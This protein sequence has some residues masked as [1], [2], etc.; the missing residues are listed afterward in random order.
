MTI[1][2]VRIQEGVSM[3]GNGRRRRRAGLL[4]CPQS[5]FLAVG[6][7]GGRLLDVSTVRIQGVAG[8]TPAPVV[9]RILAEASRHRA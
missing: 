3:G 4:K 6:L 7:L 5:T 8:S 1:D 9:A 2:R